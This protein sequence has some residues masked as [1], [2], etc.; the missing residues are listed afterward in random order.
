MSLVEFDLNVADGVSV[1]PLALRSVTY[2]LL[3]LLFFG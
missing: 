2:I 1:N 3:F